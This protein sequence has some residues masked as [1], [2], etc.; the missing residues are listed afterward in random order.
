MSPLFSLSPEGERVGV[1]G[2]TLLFLMTLTA[3]GAPFSQSPDASTT[4][5]TDAGT[6][7]AG[8]TTPIQFC[9][10]LAEAQFAFEVR[11]G[12]LT[13]AGAAELQAIEVKRCATDVSPG[14]TAGRVRF[15]ATAAHACVNSLGTVA[16]TTPSELYAACATV[17]TGTVA[18]NGD[19]FDSSECAPALFCDLSTTC[20]G[21]CKTR[22]AAGQPATGDCA[23]GAYPYAGACARF[24]PRGEPCTA[25]APSTDPRQCEPGSRCSDQHRCVSA[26][27]QTLNQP[28]G[29]GTLDCAEGLQCVNDVCVPLADVGATCSTTVS[30]RGDL[31]CTTANVCAARGDVGASCASGTEC[32]PSLFCALPNGDRAGLCASDRLVGQQCTFDGD[33]CAGGL[34]C[35]AS[36]GQSGL[37]QSPG[38]V[39]AACLASGSPFQ[40]RPGLFCASSTCTAQRF[41]GASCTAGEQCQS[42][43]CT[44][45]LCAAGVCLSP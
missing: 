5:L 28:C 31:I 13:A 22:I 26:E 34:F 43:Q 7:D 32:R 19:C 23:P 33:E 9:S 18:L 20:P 15:D 40:C 17:F 35:T 10:D 44:T 1:R 30:C 3:C 41:T 11:C 4:I 12:A 8:A 27:L 16:C 37:C 25:V 21:H 38:S 24:I 39:G 29:T 2:R 36:A 6:P 42:G 14:L 45:G